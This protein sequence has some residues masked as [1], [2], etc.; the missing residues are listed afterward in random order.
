M[1]AA[2]GIPPPIPLSSSSPRGTSSRA[3]GRDQLENNLGNLQASRFSSADAVA[4][5]RCDWTPSPGRCVST[6]LAQSRAVVVTRRHFGYPMFAALRAHHRPAPARSGRC[7]GVQPVSRQIGYFVAILNHHRAPCRAGPV[8]PDLR[9]F[10]S[11]QLSGTARTSCIAEAQILVHED[12]VGLAIPFGR[13][14]PVIRSPVA[15]TDLVVDVTEREQDADV[16]KAGIDASYWRGSADDFNPALLRKIQRGIESSP[17]LAESFY[18][19]FRSRIIIS[20][21]SG[22]RRH[23]RIHFVR[24]TG[25]HV[26]HDHLI[27]RT[28][29]GANHTT[30]R[31]WLLSAY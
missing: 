5:T 13:L 19:V 9:N 21:S 24:D 3:L 1:P 2:G 27:C 7:R 11:I 22:N 14:I 23:I 26:F 30:K 25:A 31:I 4:T 12:D 17:L 10:T 28:L 8:P 6:V 15:F 16:G 18:G 29:F 20:P